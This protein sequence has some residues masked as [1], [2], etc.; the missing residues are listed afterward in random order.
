MEKISDYKDLIVW[1][2]SM[3]LAEQVYLVSDHLPKAELY[4]LVSQM[5]RAAVSI[6]SNI[7]EGNGRYSDKEFLRY[8]SIANGSLKEVETQLYI[9]V[10]LKYLTEAQIQDVLKMC[11]SAAR[12]INGL[13]KSILARLNSSSSSYPQ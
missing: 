7:A 10:R 11:D 9:S 12:L 6:P 8:L 3:D 2:K 1:R 4:G 5:R 13:R